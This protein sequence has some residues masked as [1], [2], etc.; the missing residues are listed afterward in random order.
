MEATEGP[1]RGAV[2]RNSG[3]IQDRN[4]QQVSVVNAATEATK[5]AAK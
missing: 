5:E 3:K 4:F 2:V 1:V